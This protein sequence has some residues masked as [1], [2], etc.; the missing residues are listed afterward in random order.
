MKARIDAGTDVAMIGAWDARRGAVPLAEKMPRDLL[1]AL[2]KEV[3]SG[4]LFL[5]RTGASGGGPVDVYVDEAIAAPDL[6]RLR[7]VDGEY[8]LA[9]PSG[10]LVVA[11]TEDYR[12]PKPSGTAGKVA[13]TPGDYAVRCFAPRDSESPPASEA[14]LQ[15]LVGTDAVKRYDR[16][17][18]AI[19]MSGF[20]VPALTFAGLMKPY[21]WKVALPAS[22]FAFIGYIPLVQ[23]G[24]RKSGAYTRLHEVVNDFRIRNQDAT[25]VLVLRRLAERGSLAGGAVSLHR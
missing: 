13:V 7:P 19:V 20:L 16:I 5:I 24:V 18:L 21:G 12:A 8:F 23:L 3:E 17:N 10:E 6:A 9:V 14:E 11:G 1:G 2:A 4:D 25:M 22:I 15:R